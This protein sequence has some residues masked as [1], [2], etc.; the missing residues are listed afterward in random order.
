ME[1]KDAY[2]CYNSRDLDWVRRLAEQLESETIDG[3]PASRQLRIFFD[4]WDMGP[5]DSLIDRMNEGMEH[6]RHVVAVLTPEFIN[7]DWP[8]FEWKHIVA[9][10]PNNTTG[11]LVP[12]LLRDVS[13]DGKERINYPAPFRDLKY[14][15]F[16]KQP[17]FRRSFNE[18]IRKIRNL[19][20]ERGRKLPSIAPA[21]SVFP[22]IDSSEAAWIPDPVSEFIF[23]NLLPVKDIPFYI[24]NAATIY[25]EKEKH[26]IWDLVPNS[27]AFILR[28]GRL[29]T[30]ARLEA[31]DERL[32]QVIDTTTITRDSQR[33]WAL[34]LDRQNW[35][36]SLLNTCLNN[37]L[38]RRRIRTDGKGRF[39]FATGDAG[40]N[41]TWP[42]PTGKP[43]T[44]AKLIRDEAKNTSFWVHQ[45]A[46]VRFRRIDA[47]IFLSVVPLYLF[48][49]D[50]VATITG[51]AAGKLSQM[52]MGKQQNPDI[53]RD[54]L[55]WS[56]VMSGGGATIKMETGDQPIVLDSTPAAAKTQYGVAFDAINM[57]T[58]LQHKDTELDEAAANLQQLEPFEEDDEPEE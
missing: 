46:E 40:A 23:S 25:R 44:V 45:G 31:D 48:T 32:R 9:D 20:P 35:L 18:L 38:R 19:P 43:R 1:E 29:Y 37:H 54:V 58:L 5:G 41:R 16:R 30:F 6:A 12:I 4:R 11:R 8:R 14:I 24:W 22:S 2:I 42:M 49:E 7:A 51:K 21:A 17:D 36:M 27:Q 39:Y 28:G 26:K 55:F 33:E 3:L 57:R 15:D 56:H 13:L 52:W 34:N 53:F 47:K 10:D 50:G